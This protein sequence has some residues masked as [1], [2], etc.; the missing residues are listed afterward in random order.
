MM[1]AY[2]GVFTEYNRLAP[3]G[4]LLASVAIPIDDRF[5]AFLTWQGQ[6]QSRRDRERV[7]RGVSAV[8]AWLG[9]TRLGSVAS[10]FGHGVRKSIARATAAVC[11]GAE[12]KT[13]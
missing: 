1:F 6:M 11:V 2:Y 3:I 5:G 4:L 9:R 10:R 12:P 7:G 8:S 13:S